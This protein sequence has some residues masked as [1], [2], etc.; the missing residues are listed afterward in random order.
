MV[1][2]LV[3]AGCT[4][5]PAP[6]A[7]SAGTPTPPGVVLVLEG[8]AFDTE[9]ARE[10]A[11][12]LAREHCGRS[13]RAVAAEPPVE[14]VIQAAGARLE[15]SVARAARAESRDGNCRK[16]GRALATAVAERADTILRIRLDA[17]TT[18]QPATDA[19]RKALGGTA[20]LAGVLSAVGLGDD[21]VYETKLD[22]TI[23]RT[24]FPGSTATA[25]QRVRWSG[26]RLGD[27]DV[28]PPASVG[29][30]LAQALSAMPAAT[31]ARWEPIARGLVS[32]GCPVLGSAVADTFLDDRAAK[33]RIRA[34]ALN[35][36]APPTSPASAPPVETTT[37]PSDIATP[38]VTPEPATTPEPAYSC[39]TLCTLHMVELCN[40]D[41]SLWTR[42]GAR[43]E[44]TR[45]GLRRSESFLE[46]CY[47]MQW[48]SGTYE[49]SCVQ[50]CERADD[51]RTRLMTMLRR[52]GCIRSD[53]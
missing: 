31:A 10:Q 49:Q 51:G 3:W 53:G 27:K 50:P 6:V 52:S 15:R 41:R 17:K 35:A 22:G 42:N 13:A 37:T 33:R 11:A 18:S 48:L 12:H 47:R 20:G 2:T 46:N 39:T 14:K 19:D 29:E 21:T 30:A 34:A 40:N 32:G 44:N 16:K 38:E 25:R 4:P 7:P 1:A 24:T 36:L 23:E 26:R 8:S 28:A 43:W 9:A 5:T 45:C